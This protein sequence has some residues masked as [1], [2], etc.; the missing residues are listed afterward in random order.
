MTIP[1]PGTQV[2]YAGGP[3]P[4]NLPFILENST[5]AT[6][7]QFFGQVE[8]CERLLLL[9]KKEWS[10]VCRWDRI[11]LRV[12]VGFSGRGSSPYGI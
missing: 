11:L 7:L 8:E 5:F 4:F 3:F 9:E 2:F 12:H 1:G 10:K 6:L